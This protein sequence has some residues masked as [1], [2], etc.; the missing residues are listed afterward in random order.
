MKRSNCSDAV[1]RHDICGT[2]PGVS[3]L[4]AG[5]D[6]AAQDLADDLAGAALPV[7]AK[8]L[9]RIHQAAEAGL[10]AAQSEFDSSQVNQWKAGRIL[11]EV[12][13]RLKHGE[14]LPWVAANFSGTTRTAQRYKALAT[15]YDN[16]SHLVAATS[17]RKVAALLAEPEPE[18]RKKNQKPAWMPPAWEPPTKK[19][20]F[21]LSALIHHA[22][23]IENLD[24]REHVAEI[25]RDNAELLEWARQKQVVPAAI[26]GLFPPDADMVEADLT[27]RIDAARDRLTR[28]GR[29]RLIGLLLP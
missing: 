10:R 17:L 23:A 7:L 8:Q 16:V 4:A 27:A 5:L 19:V 15:K 20:A 14:Y 11:Q 26:A 29:E 9:N 24:F 25:G 12:K 18:K 21:H 28:E 3:T 2:G 13:A 1:V 6:I 22:T